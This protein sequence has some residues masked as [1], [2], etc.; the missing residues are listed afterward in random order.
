MFRFM[1]YY[2]TAQN[3]RN[4]H[5]NQLLRHIRARIFSGER[6]D[7]DWSMI[8][9]PLENAL[10]EEVLVAGTARTSRA[11]AARVGNIFSFDFQNICVFSLPSITAVIDGELS[12][13]LVK[14]WTDPRKKTIPSPMSL[15]FT[16]QTCLLGSCSNTMPAL[17]VYPCTI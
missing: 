4:S 13:R 2:Y 1:F 10:S 16:L 14:Q 11:I 9:F 15:S 3:G 8:N 7:L 12:S 6:H 17:L 5:F